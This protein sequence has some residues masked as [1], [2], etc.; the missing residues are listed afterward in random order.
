VCSSDLIISN[1]KYISILNY[2]HPKSSILMMNNF[3]SLN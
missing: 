1:N 2:F 3:P